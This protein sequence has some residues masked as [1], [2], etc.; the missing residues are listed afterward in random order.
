MK[1]LLFILPLFLLLFTGC[2]Q[3]DD[4]ANVTNYEECT[5]AG[6]IIL[7]TYPAQCQTPDGRS[8]TQI[9]DEPVVPPDVPGQACE[10]KCGD[11]ICQEIVCMAIGC[12][13]PETPENCP[14]DCAN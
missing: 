2:F 13:C 7:E 11:G 6:G 5:E 3:T 10:D 9:I 14:Q 12:P 8:F 1:K 4:F